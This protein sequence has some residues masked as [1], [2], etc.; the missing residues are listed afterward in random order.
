MQ[1]PRRRAPAAQ[2]LR[3]RWG[4][5]CSTGTL[6]NYAVSGAG[7]IYWLAGRFPVYAEADLDAWALGRLSGPRNT[8][9]TRQA[10]YTSATCAKGSRRSVTTGNK[11]LP[12]G[13]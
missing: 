3:E 1:N 9:H 8:S 5:P 4:I 11:R 12:L 2:Y 10:V 13:D 7:P 6:A